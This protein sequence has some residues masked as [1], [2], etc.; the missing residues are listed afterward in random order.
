M[1]LGGISFSSLSKMYSC[2]ELGERSAVPPLKLTKVQCTRNGQILYSARN[3]EVLS[4]SQVYSVLQAVLQACITVVCGV[5][6]SLEGHV[7]SCHAGLQY[8]SFCAPCA[9]G[10]QLV[11][12]LLLSISR[13]VHAGQALTVFTLNN[14]VHCA[15][16]SWLS[17]PFISS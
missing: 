14:K 5:P 10:L 17:F 1:F 16:L 13:T 11:P 4:C 9:S 2:K 7:L 3:W 12:Y 8:H 15:H 6:G